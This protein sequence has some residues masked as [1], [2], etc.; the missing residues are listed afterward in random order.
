MAPGTTAMCPGPLNTMIPCTTAGPAGSDGGGDGDT[1]E[2]LTGD[3]L[4]TCS[5]CKQDC[6]QMGNAAA[7]KSCV[8]QQT[9]VNCQQ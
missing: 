2:G 6:S 7:V 5:L 4:T 8:A 1:C 9:E 3:T